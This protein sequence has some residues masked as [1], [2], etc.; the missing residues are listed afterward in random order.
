MW[1][2]TS[3]RPISSKV[4]ASSTSRKEVRV[5]PSTTT[6]SRTPPSS[7]VVPGVRTKKASPGVAPA[8]APDLDPA[9]GRV[10]LADLVEPAACSLVAKRGAVHVPVW[11]RVQTGVVDPRELQSRANSVRSHLVGAQVQRAAA[12]VDIES[13]LATRLTAQPGQVH[14]VEDRAV[15]VRGQIDGE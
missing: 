13:E 5:R 2:G 7:R 8:F 14:R 9:G 6:D 4:R 10:E 1:W 11:A 15:L 3:A 12:R